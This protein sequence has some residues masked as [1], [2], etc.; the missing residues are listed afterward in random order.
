MKDPAILNEMG[1]MAIESGYFKDLVAGHMEVQ[2][3]CLMSL[4]FMLRDRLLRVKI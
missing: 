1:Q 2:V 3:T 4:P